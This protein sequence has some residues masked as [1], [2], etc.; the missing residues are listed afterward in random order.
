[1]TLGM[2]VDTASG[3]TSGAPPPEDALGALQVALAAYGKTLADTLYYARDSVAAGA[4]AEAKAAALADTLLA[5][6]DRVDALIDA[7][8]AFPASRR[9]V[10]AALAAAVAGRPARAAAATAALDAAL[11]TRAH[12][13]ARL[14]AAL[15]ATA[16]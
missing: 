2:A 13:A 14:A 5:A 10:E 6:A 15:A 16:Q 8:P 12:E 3:M 1:M 7:L 9:E 11:A 4:A